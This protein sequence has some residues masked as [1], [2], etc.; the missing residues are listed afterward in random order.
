MQEKIGKNYYF[1]GRKD[2]QVKISGYRVELG[3]I[4]KNISKNFE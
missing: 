2:E 3:D 1:I 4:E